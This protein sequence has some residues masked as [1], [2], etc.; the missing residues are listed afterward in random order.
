MKR[1][2]KGLRQRA[3][4]VAA[5]LSGASLVL[6][7]PALSWATSAGGVPPWDQTLNM[8]QTDLSGP[9]A[10]ALVTCSFVGSGILYAAS[11]GHGQGVNRLAAAGL[12]GSAALGAVQLMG[13]LFPYSPM[14][15]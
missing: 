5:V 8:I 9:V 12:G 11:G 14:L 13:Y 4:Q 6:L 1:I 3:G 10:H 2:V 7:T 15:F